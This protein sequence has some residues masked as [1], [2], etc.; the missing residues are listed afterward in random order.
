MSSI[1]NVVNKVKVFGKK[2]S[3]EIL[4]GIGIVGFVGT[5]VTACIATS[6]VE[7]VLDE[8]KI[9][10]SKIEEAKE[11]IESGEMDTDD[12]TQKDE[13]LDKVKFY[14]ETGVA[15]LK[16]YGPTIGLGA[17]SVY[18]IL[19]GHKILN[20][21]YVGALT[22]YNGLLGTFKKYRK[23]VVDA[24]GQDVDRAM[25]Y[26]AEYILE[27]KKNEKGDKVTEKQENIDMT[28]PEDDTARYFD[29]QNPN[30]DPNP[31]FSI[32]FLRGQQNILND[33]L[34]SRGHVFLNEVYDA[35]GFEHTPQ[36][37]VLGW[38]K[39]MG[40]DYIDFGLYDQS[41]DPIRRFVNGQDNVVLLEFNHDGV[42]WD[43]I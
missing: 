13:I 39:G 28:F 14:T 18:C 1:G 8:H 31:N 36:G 6:K 3:P 4:L 42:I 7:S 11:L 40:D 12:Y 17:M 43:M 23:N 2:N 32:M 22:A 38:V 5:V 15:L 29:A 25:R 19:S 34:Q 30:W 10:M 16:L 37:A 21:R 20:G 24:Y 26:G 35:L 41:K 33:I 27:K 9:K